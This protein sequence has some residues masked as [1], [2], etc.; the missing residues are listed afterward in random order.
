MEPYPTLRTERLVLRGFTLEDAPELH[1]LAQPR[2]V[3]RM[4]L[5]HPHPF[6]EGMA[7]EWISGLR[8]MFEVGNGTMFAVELRQRGALVGTVSLYTRAP[9]GTAVLGEEGTGLLGFWLGMPYWGKGYATEAVAEVVRYGFED[10]GLQRIKANHFGINTAS[11]KVLRKVGMSHMRTLPNYYEKWDT[12][13]DRE[14]Y[15]LLARNWRA[16]EGR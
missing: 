14:E 5:R 8:P 15:V 6:E 11:G 1:R 3:A 9:D 16:T 13:E 2:E 12:T 7:E 4:M 10:R